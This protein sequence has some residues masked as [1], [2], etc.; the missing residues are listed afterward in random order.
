M[1]FDRTEQH[2]GARLL[3]ILACLVAVVFG[4]RYAAPIL[5]PSA[6]A[7]FLA[8]LSLPVM[9]W[10]RNRRVPSWLAIMVPVL[11]NV[12]VIGLL[13]LLASQSVSDFQARLPTYVRQMQELQ[14]NW[15]AAIEARTDIVLSD[16]IT[17]DLIDPAAVV[18]FARG[19]VGRI[20][21]FVSMT[22]IV[23]LIMAFMLA[24]ASVFP[25]KFHY[26]LG[27]GAEQEDRLAKVVT[28]IQSYLGIKT[29]V[30]LAT[31][32]VLGHA[33]TKSLR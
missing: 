9:L 17:T 23:F 21:Q 5:L 32:L 27:E 25:D 11:L 33:V 7:L 18:D 10:L 14:A 15:F 2:P 30:S 8:I 28:E 13:A 16:F 24:E 4:L 3:F 26:I 19:A 20:A 6:L 29:M 31:G 1:I 22:F 12:A